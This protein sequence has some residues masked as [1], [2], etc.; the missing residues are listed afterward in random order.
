MNDNINAGVQLGIVPTRAAEWIVDVLSDA[1][2]PSAAFSLAMANDAPLVLKILNGEWILAM[3][4][5]SLSGRQRSYSLTVACALLRYVL[6]LCSEATENDIRR[7]EQTDN[8][9]S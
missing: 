5:C 4:G 3:L 9:I 2:M 7:D 8:R 6:P 1:E